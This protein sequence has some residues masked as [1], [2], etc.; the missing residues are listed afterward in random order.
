MTPN[1]LIGT[2]ALPPHIGG[3]ENIT[4][5]L[6]LYLHKN[7]HNVTVVVSSDYGLPRQKR[8][9]KIVT[10]D[11]FLLKRLPILKITRRNFAFFSSLKYTN[12]DQVILQSHLFVSNWILGLTLRKKCKVTWISY[13]GAPVKHD[14]KIMS[15]L[16]KGYEY[17]GWKI[18]DYCSN[19]RLAQSEKSAHRLSKF[20]AQTDI[21]NNCVPEF[22][23][24]S[25]SRRGKIDSVRRILF[26]GRFVED[27][28]LL[29]LLEQ[30]KVAVKRL[31]SS[32]EK[33]I[34]LSIIGDGPLKGRVIDFLKVDLKVDSVVKRLPDR[35]SVINEMLSHDL[36]IQFPLSEG[37]PG[38]TLEALTVGLPILTTPIDECLQNLD[39]VFVS[40]S[41]D[42]ASKLANLMTNYKAFEVDVEKNREHL[43]T[44]HSVSETTRRILEAK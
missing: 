22:L 6:A 7:G 26:V 16:I 29:E 31:D 21:I 33:T 3:L 11:S 42:F 1:I 44:H 8:S 13:G 14:S 5:D 19:R 12:F 25:T 23:L 39:G 30:V 40:E 37:Q 2:N 32:I 28:R 43:R 15:T 18:L 24:D 20:G 10:L 41:D 17:L 34:F 4:E 9:Y 36:L 35:N 38:V 27:K